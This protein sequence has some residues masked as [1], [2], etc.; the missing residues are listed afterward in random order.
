MVRKPQVGGSQSISINTRIQYEQFI[1]STN[2][3]PSILAKQYNAMPNVSQRAPFL[4]YRENDE[5]PNLIWGR[6][7]RTVRFSSNNTVMVSQWPPLHR[8]KRDRPLERGA[9]SNKSTHINTIRPSLFQDLSTS[10]SRGLSLLFPVFLFSPCLPLSVSNPSFHTLFTLF[11][12]IIVVLLEIG[13]RDTLVGSWLLTAE[14][15]NSQ[16]G[17]RQHGYDDRSKTM[18]MRHHGVG[19]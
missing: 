5:K 7:S 15:Q 16:E 1:E 9:A 2:P 3:Y 17:S 14:E 6:F 11:H 12:H 4:N 13:V 8:R 10:G 18:P 19:Q